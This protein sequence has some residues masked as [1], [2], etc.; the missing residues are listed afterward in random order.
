MCKNY[1]KKQALNQIILKKKRQITNLGL[2]K[3]PIM[4]TNKG[5]SSPTLYLWSND[6]AVIGE[7]NISRVVSS[8]KKTQIKVGYWVIIDDL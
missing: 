2:F 6:E 4:L 7:T 1:T 8:T 5:T 3:G